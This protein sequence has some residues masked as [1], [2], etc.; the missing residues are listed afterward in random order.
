MTRN[1]GMR[2]SYD[3]RG[4]QRGKYAERYAKGVKVVLLKPTLTLREKIRCRSIWT[5]GKIRVVCSTMDSARFRWIGRNQNMDSGYLKEYQSAES[6]GVVHCKTLPT[7][8][9]SRS[10][11]IRTKTFLRH[12]RPTGRSYKG[13]W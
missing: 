2:R 11:S 5:N 3:I 1:K 9:S 4:G 13:K 12:W 8:P 6:S 7:G 10:L